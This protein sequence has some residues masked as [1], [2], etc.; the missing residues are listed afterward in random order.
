MQKCAKIRGGEGRRG[1]GRGIGGFSPPHELKPNSAHDCGASWRA[2][3]ARA[4]ITEVWGQSPQWGPG[5]KPLVRVSWSEAPEAESI[6][7]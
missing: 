5:A 6:F 1:K 2:R 4:H 3:L 7:I